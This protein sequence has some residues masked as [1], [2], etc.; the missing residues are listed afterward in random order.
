MP[1]NGFIRRF[2]DKFL[3]NIVFY[4]SV[5][6][7]I[8]SLVMHGSLRERDEFPAGCMIVCGWPGIALEWQVY[9]IS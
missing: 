2:L 7:I 3:S 4:N 5:I 8:E 1:L 6:L 9:Y